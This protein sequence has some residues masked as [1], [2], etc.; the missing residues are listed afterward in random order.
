MDAFNLT[1]TIKIG[2]GQ[3]VH[4]PVFIFIERKCPHRKV[5]A[6]GKHESLP[7]LL[8]LVHELLLPPV[9]DV[10]AVDAADELRPAAA[11]DRVGGPVVLRHFHKIP[12]L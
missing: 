9:H 1:N 6:R 2:D 10:A 11:K 12:G 5:P 3:V 8:E 4:G 7:L